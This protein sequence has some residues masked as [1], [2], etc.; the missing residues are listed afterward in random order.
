M[1][2]VLVFS[3]FVGA[4]LAAPQGYNYQLN[5]APN[6]DG[7]LTYPQV[8]L[9]QKFAAK[10]EQSVTISEPQAAVQNQNFAP[11]GSSQFSNQLI[12]LASYGQQQQQAQL[13]QGI[14]E[15]QQAQR[16]GFSQPTPSVEQQVL[17]QVLVQPVQIQS[18][19]LAQQ[20]P[21]ILAQP[22]IQAEPRL[23]PQ[24]LLQLQPQ[25]QIQQRF[26]PQSQPQPQLVPQVQ[27]IAQLQPQPQLSRQPLPQVSPQTPQPLPQSAQ[28]IHLQHASAV[29]RAPEP[30]Y[31]NKEY[32]YL[33]APQENYELPPDFNNLLSKMKKNLRVVFIKAPEQNGLT[34]TALQLLKDSQQPKT[35]IYVLTKQHSAVELAK[36]LQQQP[37]SA[38]QKPEVI[39][40]KYRTRQ[41]AE[42]AQRTIQS[43]Y[44]SLNGPN[45]FNSESVVP[46]QNVIGSTGAIEPRQRPVEQSVV[47]SVT[48]PSPLDYLPPAQ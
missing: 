17:H 37:G 38:Q 26:L 45:H 6:Y 35:A 22:Q 13:T 3:L 48:T 18:S 7:A 14:S 4:A 30:T 9:L 20:L 43:Q 19:Q 36:K 41:E 32:Y 25:P 39:F 46:T 44:E 5:Y 27:A 21:Q 8:Q 47:A 23:Q 29:P 12:Q 2:R 34:K 24:L 31:Y 33:S 40:I 11:A 42:H 28:P 10:Q 16:Q 15:V 1:M